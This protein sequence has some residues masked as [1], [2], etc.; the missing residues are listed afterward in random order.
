M[1]SASKYWL[2]LLQALSKEESNGSYLKPRIKGKIDNNFLSLVLMR[3]EKLTGMKLA[4]RC[5]NPLIF[6]SEYPFYDTGI[7]LHFNVLFQVHFE[8]KHVKI[9]RVCHCEW[10]TWMLSILLRDFSL[11]LKDWLT[12][13]CTH[14]EISLNCSHFWRVEDPQ[15]AHKFYAMVTLIELISFIRTFQ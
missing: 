10:S 6:E 13:N 1:I 12:G 3:L 4:P 2:D 7:I 15:S 5:Y 8:L 14:F 9:W 11:N